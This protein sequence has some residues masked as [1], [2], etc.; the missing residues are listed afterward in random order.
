MF[1]AGAGSTLAGGEEAGFADG[2]GAAARFDMPRS[3]VQPSG[4][5]VVS[6]FMNHALRVVTPGG[7]VRTLAGSGEPGFADGQGAAVRF[8]FPAGPGAGRGREERAGGGLSQPRGAT[9]DDGRGGE[10][11]RGQ[12][13]GRFADGE[14]AAA[15]FRCPSRARSWWRTRTATGCAK[16][17]AGR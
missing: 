1:Q 5:F 11:G 2:Q 14:G 16:S 15:R 12:R 8:N 9:G 6:A 7:A 13:G 4:E 3:V 17:G 10:H